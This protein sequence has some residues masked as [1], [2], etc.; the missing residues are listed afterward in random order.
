MTKEKKPSMTAF[1]KGVVAEFISALSWA[2]TSPAPVDLINQAT[3]C[4]NGVDQD[5]E[6]PDGSH[7]SG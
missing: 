4:L 2:E 3:T 5:G 1:V 7:Y 6:M